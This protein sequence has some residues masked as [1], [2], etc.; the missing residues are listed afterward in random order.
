MAGTTFTQYTDS[1]TLARDSQAV[2][3]KQRSVFISADLKRDSINLSMASD[4]GCSIM[5]FTVE[6]ARAIAA[7][8]L[9]C[10]DAHDAAQSPNSGL[11]G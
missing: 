11:E 1:T 10:A 6:Q 3:T 4:A 5:L 9:A 7:E 8:L 2:L